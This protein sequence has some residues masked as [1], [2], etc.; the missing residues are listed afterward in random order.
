MKEQRGSSIISLP[1]AKESGNHKGTILV[2]GIGSPLCPLNDIHVSDVINYTNCVTV[3]EEVREDIR[4]PNGN[5]VEGTL[6]I[7]EYSDIYATL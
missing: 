5:K 2:K 1:T 3:P 6:D 7:V 4:F